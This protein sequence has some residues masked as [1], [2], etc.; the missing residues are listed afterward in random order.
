MSIA[1]N[2]I[3]ENTRLANAITLM[4]EKLDS[5]AKTW[6]NDDDLHTLIERYKC[7]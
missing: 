6:Y 1:S 2:V 3:E 7:Y 5:Q 4:H